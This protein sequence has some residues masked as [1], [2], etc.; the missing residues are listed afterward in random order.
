MDCRTPLQP[1][2]EL[3]LKGLTLQIEI[4]LGQGANSIVYRAFYEDEAIPGQ[5]HHVLVKELFPWRPDGGIMRDKAGVIHCEADAE[6][7]SSLH[8]KSFLRGNKV[9]LDL[10]RI[11]ADKV[12]LNWN[13]YPAN[14]TLYTDRKS[15]V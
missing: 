14:G 9:H 1:G 7:F 12:P 10:Q 4:C 5:F 15:V 13:T 6:D 3:H 2:Y 8:R 11:R